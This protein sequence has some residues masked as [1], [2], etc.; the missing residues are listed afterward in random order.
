MKLGRKARPESAR[1]L[2]LSDYHKAD[3][4]TA[5]PEWDGTPG[6]TFKMYGNSAYGDCTFAGLANLASVQAAAEGSSAEFDEQAVIDAYLRHTGGKDEGAVEVDVLHEVTNKGFPGDGT[7]RIRA[8]AG[9]DHADL[10]QVKACAV[11]YLGVYLGV[12][13]PDD[14]ESGI[15]AGYWEAT[16]QPDPAN[17]HCVVVVGYTATDVLLATWGTVQRASW[18]W[19][20]AY[21]VEAYVLLDTARLGTDA[22]NGE[23]LLSDAASLASQSGAGS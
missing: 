11:T 22:L 14:W 19:F 18:E 20:M 16:S 2:R 10:E 13:L 23:R 1:F 21:V 3:L 15:Q 8:W 6:T 9:V 5:P 4:P 7:Y 12:E 17:G